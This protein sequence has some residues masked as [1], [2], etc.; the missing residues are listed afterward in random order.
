[1]FAGTRGGRLGKNRIELYP[2]FLLE[3]KRVTSFLVLKG[4]VK[5]KQKFEAE[6]LTIIVR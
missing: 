6:T 5:G 4:N 3:A 1:M 2:K